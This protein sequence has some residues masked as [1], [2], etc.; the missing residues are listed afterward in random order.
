MIIIKWGILLA[1]TLVV[2]FV[3]GI[4]PVKYMNKAQKNPSI[5]YISGWFV[6][7][8]VFET[9]AIPFILLKT[10]FTKLVVCYTVV[11]FALLVYSM[12]NIKYVL[13]IY[14]MPRKLPAWSYILWC[15]VF[16]I[17][18]AQVYMAIA[19]EYYDGDDAY[20][21][22]ESVMANAFDDMYVR[23]NY[24]TYLSNFDLRHALS[25]TPLYISWLSKISRIHPAIIAHSVLSVVWLLLMYM[26]YGQV[27]NRLLVDARQYKPLFMM[28]I[29]IWFMFGNV[30]ML[31]AETFSMTR[32]WQGKGLM[33]GVVLPTLMLC[34]MHLADK[35]VSRGMWMLL[36]T[37]VVASAMTTTVAVMM[38]PTVI[39]IAAI[40]IGIQRK[41][42]K[43]F[44]CIALCSLPMIVV[45]LIYMIARQ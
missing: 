21:I 1:L 42:I 13:D 2:P 26:V 23:D 11:I 24:T 28:F 37:V 5:T 36:V 45:G 32:T 15:I 14:K 7:F 33:A 41:D 43:R 9:V 31:T 16:L 44:F 4:V 19:Y 8:A 10:S 39:G 20:Y 3:L 40:I 25:P 6:S 35:K 34:I 17:I 12:L 27:A 30:S 18:G 38:I 22:A 29:A